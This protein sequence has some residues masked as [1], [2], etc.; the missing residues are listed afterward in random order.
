VTLEGDNVVFDFIAKSGK[1]RYV[2]LGD[3]LVRSAVEDLLSRHGGSEDLLAYREAGEWR[4]VTSTDIN[5][6]V[7]EVVGGEVSAKDFR[8]WHGTVIAAVALARA[9]DNARSMT[10]RKRAVS[11]AMKEVSAYLGNTPTVARASYVD[12]R[13]IDLFNDGATISPKL[14]ATDQNLADG[15]THGKIERAVLDLLSAPKSKVR[16]EYIKPAKERVRSAA[17][18]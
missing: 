1:E 10:A 8:T 4:D 13:V 9:T 14:A 5:I 12:P 15:F 7:K 17:E 18:V 16:E 2:A 6:Y 11:N 3:D